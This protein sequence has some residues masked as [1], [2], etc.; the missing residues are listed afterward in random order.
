MRG[1]WIARAVLL[2]VFVC[3]GL[4]EAALLLFYKFPCPSEERR[5]ANYSSSIEGSHFSPTANFELTM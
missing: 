1:L 3:E 2:Q 5:R 4:W